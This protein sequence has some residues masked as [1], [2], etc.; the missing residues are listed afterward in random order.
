MAEVLSQQ[1][2]DKLLSGMSSGGLDLDKLLQESE[3]EKQRE[4]LNYDF[5]LPN[6]VSKNQL[7]TLHT[8]H[9]GFAEAFGSHMVSK[10]QSGVTVNVTSV[11]QLFY[12]E[13]ILS[14]TSP[15]CLY[16][17][18]I[19]GTDGAGILEI[20]PPLVFALVERLLGGNGESQKKSRLITN[21]EQGVMQNV[22]ET[23][24]VDLQTAW[25]SIGNL[26]FKL[27]RFESEPDFVQIAPASEIVLVVSFEV[28]LGTVPYMMNLGLPIFAL[29]ETIGK[30][31]TQRFYHSS[32]KG[33]SKTRP[34]IIRRQMGVTRMPVSA[35]LGTARIT[36]NDLVNLQ[37]GDVIR[38]DTRV[39]GEVKVFISGSHKCYGR[40]GMVDGRRALKITRFVSTE[41][42]N[43][44]AS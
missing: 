41:D 34:D 20:S 28:S 18:N 4:I 9:E 14:V 3:P 13:F 1:E 11:D 15:S 19:E 40:P 26:Q 43:E 24:F 2:I 39:D 25:K 30:L 23:I 44:E 32:S 7:R 36:M 16:V 6:R 33:N 21:I 27:D 29:E 35:T 5:R 31:N 38:L 12:S 42:I 37:L 17:F 22:V 8:V 10:L